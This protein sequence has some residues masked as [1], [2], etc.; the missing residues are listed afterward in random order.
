[1]QRIHLCGS[2]SRDDTV[3]S[4]AICTILLEQMSSNQTGACVIDCIGLYLIPAMG[5]LHFL[6]DEG[7]RHGDYGGG[8]GGGSSSLNMIVQ[9]A[10]DLCLCDCPLT[11]TTTTPT[12]QGG[13]K[14]NHVLNLLSL[15]IQH[16]FHWMHTVI[17]FTHC[18]MC[19]LALLY[20]SRA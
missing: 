3:S 19:I 11:P 1:M 14:E 6:F 17:H 5:H 2:L 16:A 15:C 8:R 13:N 18:D 20:R 12:T 9:L 7:R 4:T 10:S